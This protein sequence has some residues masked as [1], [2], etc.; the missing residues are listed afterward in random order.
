[1]QRR[2]V[3][4][5]PFEGVG[6]EEASEL[7]V[8]VAGPG[9]VEAGLG[10]AFVAGEAE[11]VGGGAGDVSGLSPGVPLVAGLEGAGGLEDGGDGAEGVEEVVAA[12]LGGV[13]EG[14]EAV[15]AVVVL[16]DGVSSRDDARLASS[17]RDL[18][19]PCGSAPV[20]RVV[21]LQEDGVLVVGVADDALGA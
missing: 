6:G 14:E 21:A 5:V 10:V 1:M 7:G 11:G 3:V 2:R 19:S 4:G 9:V 15:G 17:A 18:A 8:V 13:G 12:A 20:F 16:G